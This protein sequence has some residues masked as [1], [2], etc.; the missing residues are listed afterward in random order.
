MTEVP[1]SWPLEARKLFKP[2]KPLGT[3]GFGT[4]WLAESTSEAKDNENG[5]TVAIKLV[6]HPSSK[7]MS[8]LAKMSELGYFHREVE[9]LQEISHPRIVKVLRKIEESAKEKEETPQASPYCMVLAFCRGPTLE[10][11]LNHGGAPGIFMG[12]EIAAQLIDA[13]S[14]LHGR[15][16]IHRDIKP[17]NIV[18]AGAKLEGFEACWSDGVEG[19]EAAKKR[20][21]NIKLIDFG[22]A[23][24]LHPDDIEGYKH[25]VAVTAEPNDEF[26]GRSN[27]D[28]AIDL[29]DSTRNDNS[30]SMSNSI[31]HRKIRGLSAV[32]NRNYAA[33]EMLKGIRGFK[34]KLLSLSSSGKNK[35]FNKKRMHEQSLAEAISDYGMT[36]DAYSIGT[37]IRYMLTGVPPDVSVSD[38]MADKNSAVNI[39]GRKL[40][41]K[42]SKKENAS[43]KKRYKYTSQLPKEA[44]KVVLGLTH[45]NERSR[46]TV[47]SARNFEW[48]QSSYSMK[49]ENEHPS[50]NDHRGKIDFLKCALER[51]V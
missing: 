48:I 2:I 27:I 7:K 23:R 47:R 33:P 29:D 45:W 20:T 24:P 37:T 32:G 50:S 36:A 46:T 5:K 15:G 35:D 13:V 14:F 11:I 43:R 40:K 44:A 30:L 19:E 12:R 26:F 17:D 1:T 22:F 10:Q 49:D 16:V 41:K 8:A 21:W 28:H 31:S 25:N 34:K 4:V 39:I 3:G 18:V 38:F 6:G 51:R 42:F 9:V